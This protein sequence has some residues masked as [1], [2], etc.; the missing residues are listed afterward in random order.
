VNSNVHQTYIK[1]RAKPQPFRSL[2]IKI[3]VQV[4]RTVTV[5]PI[6]IVVYLFIYAAHSK[7]DSFFI[8]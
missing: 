3:V 7:T 2:V 1:L 4:C 6:Q 5:G 8:Q